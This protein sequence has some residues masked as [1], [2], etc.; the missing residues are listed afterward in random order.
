MCISETWCSS[1]RNNSYLHELL[2]YSSIHQTRSS[3]N[4]GGGTTI[5]VH[6]SLTFSVRKDLVLIVKMLKQSV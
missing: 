2:N 1:E 5:F 3:G 6:N 4:T